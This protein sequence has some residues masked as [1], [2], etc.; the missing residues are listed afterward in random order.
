MES[1]IATANT[2]VTY[3]QKI[4]FIK[5]PKLTNAAQSQAPLGHTARS[6]AGIT[7]VFSGHSLP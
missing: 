1:E 7:S 2:V 3:S 6:I 5:N 4:A